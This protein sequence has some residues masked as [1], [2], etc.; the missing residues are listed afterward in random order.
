MGLKIDQH[1][2]YF[3]IV[4]S[5][6]MLSCTTY[7]KEEKNIMKDDCLSVQSEKVFWSTHI[8]QKNEFPLSLYIPVSMQKEVKMFDSKIKELE[9]LSNSMLFIHLNIDNGVR[10]LHYYTW[11]NNTKVYHILLNDKSNTIHP[12][13]DIEI[14]NKDMKIFE[15]I[16]DLS[17]SKNMFTD[18]ENKFLLDG[19]QIYLI[20]KKK[21]KIKRY[22]TYSMKFNRDIVVKD[23]AK[24]IQSILEKNNKP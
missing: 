18:I 23:F 19:S 24:Y 13:C 9:C 21:Q 11:D 12:V 16:I 3:I 2:N 7:S 10:K 14:I 1:I 4:T 17:E 6:F 20:I 15:E 22:G 5:F 8:D